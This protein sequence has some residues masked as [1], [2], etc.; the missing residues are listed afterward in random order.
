MNFD[1]RLRTLLHEKTKASRLVAGKILVDDATAREY[2]RKFFIGHFVRRVV[3]DRMKF[4]F[5]VGMIKALF[6]QSR[7]ARMIFTWTR[8]EN[9]VV[10]FDL[11][12]RDA[13]VIGVTAARSDTQ[14]VKDFSW[15]IE[16]E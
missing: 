16:T 13:V 8:P 15:R 10:L 3:F 6:K 1:I 12:P 9:P 2:Q 14:L 11:L 5:A 7:C 4:R